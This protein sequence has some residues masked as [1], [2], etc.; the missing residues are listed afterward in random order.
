MERLEHDLERI[1]KEEKWNSITQQVD[2]IVDGLKE[3]IDAGIKEV[4]VGLKAHDFGTMGSCEGHLDHGLPYPW[5][6]VGS[7]IAEEHDRLRSR[8]SEL[9]KRHLREIRKEEVMNEEEKQELRGMLE[10]EIAAN[11]ET[12]ARFSELL[13]QYNEL[14]SSQDAGLVLKK[15]F[16]NRA[17]LQPSNIPDGRLKEIKEELGKLPPEE[18]Q[19]NL[20]AYQD[21]MKKF[22]IF[23]KDHFFK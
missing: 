11:G 18:L 21:E 1:Q 17:R 10:E 5:V 14:Q 22:A 2:R 6:A 16:N 7:L 9:W 4:I 19:N 15:T 23:L 8:F 12:L 13:D 20:R 3:P